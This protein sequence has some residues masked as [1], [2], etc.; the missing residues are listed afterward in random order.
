MI[1]TAGPA[2]TQGKEEGRCRCGYLG[3]NVWFIDHAQ[4]LEPDVLWLPLICGKVA[5]VLRVA[6]AG[7]ETQLPCLTKYL[8]H[9]GQKLYQLVCWSLQSSAPNTSEITITAVTVPGSPA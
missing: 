9:C 2:T 7:A 8:L 5:G 6:C 1:E 3:Y 4:H